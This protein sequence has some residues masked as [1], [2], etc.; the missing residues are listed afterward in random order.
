ML[1]IGRVA[2]LNAILL[3]AQLITIPDSSANGGKGA[4]LARAMAAGGQIGRWTM[5][6]A[7]GGA[8]GAPSCPGSACS[9]GERS[10]CSAS[11]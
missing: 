8:F 1:H 2:R 11:G 9:S 6:V 3:A 4:L 10:S 7:F 5:M